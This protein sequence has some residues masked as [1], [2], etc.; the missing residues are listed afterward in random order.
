MTRVMT[1]EEQREA[2]Q[3]YCLSTPKNCDR[4]EIVTTCLHYGGNPTVMSDIGVYTLYQALVGVFGLNTTKE[5]T[6]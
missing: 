4:C 5:P 6:Q 3:K 1:T 2:I